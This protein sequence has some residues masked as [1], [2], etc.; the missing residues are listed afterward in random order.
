MV[1]WEGVNTS[2]ADI[3]YDTLVEKLNRFASPTR[4][5]CCTNEQKTCA[6]QGLDPNRC[7]ASFSF[8]CS[9]SMYYN[10][11]KYARS[12]TV[13]KFKMTDEYEER[14]V[15]EK[16][17]ILASDIAPLYQCLAPVSFGNQCKYDN[18]AADCRLGV[19]P[20]RPF[21]GVTACMDF[22]A[23][24]HRDNHNMNEGCTVV[25][26]LSKNKSKNQEQFHVFPMYLVDEVDEFGSKE[27]QMEKMRNGSIQVLNR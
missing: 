22:C 6:C 25:V 7:G 17:Q 26:T 10:G 5:R 14:I 3:L 12:R 8:G 24:A 1:A 18:V 20:G 4:R 16:L 2:T 15:E 13:R 23:H 19:R 9:W 11:C 27:G 21:S